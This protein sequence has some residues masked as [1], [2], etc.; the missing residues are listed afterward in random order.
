[1]LGLFVSDWS[2]CLAE[3]RYVLEPGIWGA[4]SRSELWS[5][6]IANTAIAFGSSVVWN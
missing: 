5:F 4:M 3:V 1:M 2:S 6:V